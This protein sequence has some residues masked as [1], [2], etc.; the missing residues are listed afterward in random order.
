VV[1]P[2]SPRCS[3]L[4]RLQLAKHVRKLRIQTRVSRSHRPRRLS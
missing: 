2:P 1:N 3:Y 4:H